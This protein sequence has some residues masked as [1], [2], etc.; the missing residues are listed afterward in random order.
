MTVT[1]YQP[2]K[3][4]PMYPNRVLVKGLNP[5]ISE[6]GIINYLEVKSGEDVIDVTYGQEEGTALITFEE[7]RGLLLFRFPDNVHLK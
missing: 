6:D 3:L 1:Q 5:Q 2:R 7:L 4:I